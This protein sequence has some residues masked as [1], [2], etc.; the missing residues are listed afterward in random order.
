MVK[1]NGKTGP[2]QVEERIPPRDY[3]LQKVAFLVRNARQGRFGTLK[4]YT[5]VDLAALHRAL[6]TDLQP[7]S[8]LE[9][10]LHVETPYAVIK[11]T[12]GLEAYSQKDD[13]VQIGS[14]IFYKSSDKSLGCHLYLGQ[15]EDLLRH[16]KKIDPEEAIAEKA[17][18]TLPHL[19][20]DLGIIVAGLL[21]G[22]LIGRA[23]HLVG[24]SLIAGSTLYGAGDSARQIYDATVVSGICTL[25]LTPAGGKVDQ[26]Q[27]ERYQTLLR[28]LEEKYQRR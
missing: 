8:P 20:K 1:K 16:D 10:T 22:G 13:P 11:T 28:K 7:F 4:P 27:L 19:A 25:A 21:G 14:T 3:Q 6:R 15:E 9:E 24:K 26:E 23:S 2:A 5:I 18:R 17:L 12:S